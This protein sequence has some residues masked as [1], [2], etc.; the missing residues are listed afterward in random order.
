MGLVAVPIQARRPFIQKNVLRVEGLE[1]RGPFSAARISGS[2]KVIRT[3][4]SRQA[5]DAD[6]LLVSQAHHST[7][8]MKKLAASAC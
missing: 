4:V 5:N 8:N 3:Q 2:Y 6:A 7:N 1:F